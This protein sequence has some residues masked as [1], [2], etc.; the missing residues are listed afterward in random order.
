MKTLVL[1]DSVFGNTQKIA[2]AMADMPDAQ[3]VSVTNVK[4]D[5]IKGLSLLLVGSPTRGFRPTPAL[6]EWLK[7]LPA[8]ALKGVPAAAFDTRIAADKVK[9]GMLKF[10][11]KKFGWAAPAIDKALK[12]K[13]AT[14]VAAPSGFYVEESEGPLSEGEEARAVAWAR[15]LV[16]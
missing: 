9:S 16:K 7:N 12:K 11:M 10:M 13:G 8:D 15:G 14:I 4:T 3:A 1:Y 2:A 6:A 5:D